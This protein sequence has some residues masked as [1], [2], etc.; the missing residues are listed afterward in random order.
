M[1][2][3]IMEWDDKKAAKI[4]TDET[5]AILKRRE[6]DQ[7]MFEPRNGFMSMSDIE[8][9]VLQHIWISEEKHN[10]K[11]E[12]Y[13]NIFK[14][15]MPTR[16]DENT[17]SVPDYWFEYSRCDSPGKLLGWVRQL[18]GKVWCTCDMIDELIHKAESIHIY[19][20]GKVLFTGLESAEG[21]KKQT[22]G[23]KK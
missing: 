10:G 6:L 18:V 14:N 20:T 21:F 2:N 7:V 5:V 12:I 1:S 22:S 23:V 15:K 13:F 4:I 11:K 3:T 8:G 16:P 9:R 19:K 17:L